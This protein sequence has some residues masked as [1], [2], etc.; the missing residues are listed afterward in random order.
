MW[1]SN[2]IMIF[3]LAILQYMVYITILILNT[4]SIA[5][6]EQQSQISI[7]MPLKYIDIDILYG[8]DDYTKYY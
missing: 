7:F 5:K 4:S 8:R 2:D 1:S 6:M 3:F